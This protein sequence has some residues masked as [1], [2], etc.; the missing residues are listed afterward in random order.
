MKYKDYIGVFDSGVGGISVLKELINVLPNEN[1]IFYG[2]S[3]NSPYGN[4]PKQEILDLSMNIADY[5]IENGVKAIV[6]ACNTATSAAAKEIR[7]KY[8]DIPVLGIE[9]AI[10]PAVTDHPNE[11]ILV[12]A[13][14]AT[15]KLEKFN[16]QKQKLDSQNK[17]IPI[18]CSG[19][20]EAIE[21]KLDVTNL[22]NKYLLPLKNEASIVVLG[23]THYPFIKKEIIQVMG[24]VDFYDGA[25]ATALNLRGQLKEKNKLNLDNTKGK[26]IFK[27]SN[28]SEKIYQEFL[29]RI[30]IENYNS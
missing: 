2:D 13:T 24:P 25:Y 26:V 28:N 17:I 27:S 22:L 11:K 14:E 19:L 12:M 15:I 21:Q 30:L 29:N 5:L 3:L 16:Q 4:K 20:A 23:C 9:P 18:A 1:Y 8:P 7:E 10:K 6:I